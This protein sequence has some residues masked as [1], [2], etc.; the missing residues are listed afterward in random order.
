MEISLSN[1]V[2]IITGAA[3]GIGLATVGMFLES[4][5]AGVIAV[6]QS[7]E[8]PSSLCE[9]HSKYAEKL[10]YVGG[11]LSLEPTA[12]EYTRSALERFGRIDTL[13]SNAGVSVVK[14]LHEHTPEEWDHVMNVNVKAMYW[15]ARHVIPVM[16]KTGGT[17]L[18]SG[19]I[20]GEVGIPGQGAYAASKGALHE[21]TRQMAIEY[22]PHRIRVNAI[23]CGTVDTP[24]VHWSAS[25][26]GDPQGF[27]AK[28][29]RAHPIGRIAQP[30]EVAK[31]F[32]Y[33]ASDAASFFTGSILMMDG[34]FTAQ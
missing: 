23:G 15:A 30:E 19:S 25:A 33:M 24:L 1:K 32:V 21:I 12:I 16:M 5:A 10:R 4:G 13:I 29:E 11:D 17:I 27:M 8:L 7:T 26:S 6:D 14:A 34:G 28:L 9:W 22:A 31:F 20:S 18:I 3:S 2:A